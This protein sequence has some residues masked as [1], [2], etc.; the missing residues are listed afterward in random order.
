MRER[1]PS[2]I[3]QRI[4]ILLRKRNKMRRT[5]KIEQADYI[6]VNRLIVH[7]RSTALAGA[8]NT[9]TKQLWG[10]FKRTGYWGANKQTV[11]NIH[12]NQINDYFVNIST[13]TDYD[14]SAV[15][16]VALRAPHHAAIFVKYKGIVLSLF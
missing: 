7:N 2:Y 16:K 1:D 4:K 11:S 6:A 12:S 14:L 9:D 8:S 13:D 3:T 5:G 10:F 15:I